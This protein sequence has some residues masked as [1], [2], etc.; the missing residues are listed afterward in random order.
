MQT[1][2]LE[3]GTEKMITRKLQVRFLTPAFLGDAEQNGQWRTPPF[4][5]LLREWWRVA[6]AAHNDLSNWRRMREIEGGLFGHAWL[7]PK[8]GED[9]VKARRSR[10]LVRL[11]PW[12]KGKLH[13]MPST[14]PVGNGRNAVASH[15][16]LGYGPVK[17]ASELKMAH[18]LSP[19]KDL[20]GL[21]LAWPEGGAGTEYLEDTLVLIHAFGT[22]GGRSRN[23]WG[24]LI[25][26]RESRF[27]SLENLARF[28]KPWRDC[29]R[30]EW[31]HA[32][33]EDKGRPLIWTTPAREKWEAIIED[34][35]SIRK[36]VNALAK[37][38][39]GREIVNQPVAGKGARVPSTLRFK[40]RQDE[41]GRLYGVIFHMPC[42]PPAAFHPDDAALHRVWQQVHRFL[43]NHDILERSAS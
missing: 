18:P 38:Q 4:K 15:L 16:Y 39:R 9:E 22:L 24:S 43:D 20:A 26:E 5:H 27:L 11:T 14:R 6:W 12:A 29:L 7:D 8:K 21:V 1:Q 2:P 10:V 41:N 25:L 17:S 28:V 37:Q 40:V 30:E 33:G 31:A 34:L 36:Q 3:T 19:S 32:I 42:K 13:S 35:A 23:G